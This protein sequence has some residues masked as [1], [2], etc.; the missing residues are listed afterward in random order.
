[1]SQIRA[2]HFIIMAFSFSVLQDDQDD[3][4]EENDINAV[5]RLYP[6][7][8]Y[9]SKILLQCS[10]KELFKFLFRIKNKLPLENRH[11]QELLLFSSKKLYKAW[12]S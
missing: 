7:D 3:D 5:S 11:L 10:L 9:W 4:D 2:K 6:I 8:L 12:E 1:M